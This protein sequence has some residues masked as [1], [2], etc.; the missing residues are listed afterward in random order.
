LL[1]GTALASVIVNVGIVITGGAVRLT[2]SGLGCPTWPQCTDNSYTPSPALGIYGTIE[3]GNRMLTFVV[4]LVAVGGIILALLDRPRRTRLVRLAVLV[5]IGVCAQA[6]IGGVSVRTKLNPDVV[7]GHFLISIG[8]IAAA[9]A[10]W[11][12]TTES[13]E[14]VRPTVP[15]PLR[16]LAAVLTVASIA[17]IFVGT[18]VTGSGPHA[19]DAAAARNHLN[20]ATISQVHADLVFL[21]IG[22]TVAT[23]FAFRAVGERQA[24]VT[25]LIGVIAAQGL[26]GFVQYLTNL[27]AILVGAHMA[28]A[29]A[30]WV[31]TL[32]VLYATRTRLPAP[33]SPDAAHP[34]PHPP[35]PAG[36]LDVRVPAETA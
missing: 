21:L 33:A 15:R 32:G 29:C 34:V 28:G 3:F 1:R 16:T 2:G 7:G 13:D 6:V 31:A 8:L 17:V 35:A 5:F 27:P 9:Y 4:G 12:A 25:W 36:E 23:W 14:P 18:L 10:F 20:P 30:V 11:R 22:L 19:G 24:T 26:I